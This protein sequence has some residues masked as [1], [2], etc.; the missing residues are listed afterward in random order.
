MNA[1]QREYAE[2]IRKS[3]DALLSIINDIL[4]FSKIE[5]NKLELESHPFDLRECIESALDLVAYQASEKGL[6][7]LYNVAEDIPAVVIGDV[8]R[9][10]QIIANLLGNAVKFTEKGEVEVSAKLAESRADGATLQFA[11]RDTGIG[12]P[13]DQTN[14]LQPVLADR[15]LHHKAFW[16]D[17]VGLIH[18]QTAGG[19]NG[20]ANLD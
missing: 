1:E 17:R 19:F 12:I 11:V 20:R 7:L 6:E 3:G 9:L 15:R 8:T 2:T 10:R 4:D 18:L 14:R 13:S 5:A 16:R